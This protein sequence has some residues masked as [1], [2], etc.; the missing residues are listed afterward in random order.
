MDFDLSTS[1]EESSEHQEGDKEATKV[2]QEDGV[3][4]DEETP[5]QDWRA[6]VVKVNLQPATKTESDRRGKFVNPNRYRLHFEGE[7]KEEIERRKRLA[8]SVPVDPLP[9]VSVVCSFSRTL[10]LCKL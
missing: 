4:P 7:S 6:T 9:E 5:R 8:K 3:V 10:E 1:S 2:D